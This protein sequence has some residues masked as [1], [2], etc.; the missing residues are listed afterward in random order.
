MNKALGSIFALG[1]ILLLLGC[2][3]HIR[4]TIIDASA[5]RL[6]DDHI[7]ITATYE[8]GT[9]GYSDCA[10]ATPHCLVARWYPSSVLPEGYA[11]EDT[12]K[13]KDIDGL[14]PW[15]IDR[16]GEALLTTQAC[17][18]K[19]LKM[20]E[21]ETLVLRTSAPVASD[22]ELVIHLAFESPEAEGFTGAN[23]ITEAFA[24]LRNP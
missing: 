4:L 11:I 24:V 1:I 15:D 14:N 18:Q 12:E 20:D 7:Q 5:E 2:G 8:C 23:V 21:Q 6:D 17:Q 13:G 9:T 10:A 3:N 16:E 19:T 22:E